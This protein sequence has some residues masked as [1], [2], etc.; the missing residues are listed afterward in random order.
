LEVKSGISQRK[1][2][3]GA[4]RQIQLQKEKEWEDCSK[5]SPGVGES[6]LRARGSRK[7]WASQLEREVK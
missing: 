6:I 7:Q 1:K 5:A 2:K 4:Q 3:G